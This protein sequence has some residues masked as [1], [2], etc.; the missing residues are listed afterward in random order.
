VFIERFY[1]QAGYQQGYIINVFGVLRLLK[2][3][4]SKIMEKDK[5]IVI[6]EIFGREYVLT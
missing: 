3:K 4:T 2:Y 5:F 1:D 6:L